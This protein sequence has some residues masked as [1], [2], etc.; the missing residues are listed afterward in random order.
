MS[1]KH[2]DHGR[3]QAGAAIARRVVLACV[4]LMLGRD[5][6]HAEDAGAPTTG[7]ASSAVPTSADAGDGG[8][9]LSEEITEEH[10]EERRER[11]LS[12][13]SVLEPD[14]WTFEWRNGLHI[15]RGDGQFELLVGAQTMFEGA[16]FD[17]DEELPPSDS[18]WNADSDVRR[19]RVF[20]Q[21]TLAARWYFKVSYELTNTEFTDLYVGVLDVGPARSLQLGYMRS[22]FSIEQVTSLRNSLFLERSLADA[23]APKRRSGLIA[24]GVAFEENLRWA[25]GGF[26]ESDWTDPNEDDVEGLDGT[27]AVTA[28]LNG[29]PIWEDDG[30]HLLLLGLSLERFD[31][32]TT[33]GSVSS[34]PET[35]L[36]GKLVSTGT[37]SDIHRGSRVG[38][39]A[40]WVRG[41]LTLQGEALT[42]QLNRRGA[43]DVGFWGGYLQGAWILTGEYRRYG[44]ASGVFGRLVPERPFA[45]RKGQWGAVELAA[46]ISYLDLN[47]G[48]IRGGIETNMTAGVNWYLRTNL[49]LTANCIHGHVNGDGNVDVIQARLQ[50]DF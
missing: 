35:R 49:R 9:A 47:D 44:R 17:V 41:P 13:G 45:P 38:V 11:L 28:R 31:T 39:E 1:T 37:I 12:R 46:R 29:T 34:P 19:A 32:P 23:L 8:E 36:V 30:R 27:W 2:C 33:N 24:S 4:V 21:G 26:Y 18:G 42:L 16:V 15:V 3:R 6:G 43:S 20:A 22:P 7:P 25:I 40:A 5:V 50:L 14:E 10:P 48:A